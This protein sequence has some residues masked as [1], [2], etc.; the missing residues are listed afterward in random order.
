MRRIASED[1][2][3]KDHHFSRQAKKKTHSLYV[4]Q[5]CVEREN[6]THVSHLL[7]SRSLTYYQ[8]CQK[9]LYFNL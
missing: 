9:W 2:Y 3:N 1:M 6:A 7:I 8:N 5:I 4:A